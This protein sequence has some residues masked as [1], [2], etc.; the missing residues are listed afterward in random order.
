MFEWITQLFN[1]SPAALTVRAQML[2]PNDQ[3]R[4]LWDIFF[5]RVEV[6]SV[7]LADVLTLDDRAAADRREWNG[8][9]RLIPVSS[10]SLRQISMIPIEAYDKVDEKEMQ[11]LMERFIGNAQ[12]IAD[13]IG[14]SL[15]QRA[16]RLAMACWRRH[17]LDCFQAW[18]TGTVIQRN[19]QDA[20]KTYTASFGI[21]ASRILTAATAWNDAGVN[22]YDLLLAFI[23]AGI[24]AVGS[25]AGVMLRL[26]TL[27]VIQ[28]DAPNLGNSVKMTRADLESRIQ[29]DIGG[30]FSFY[31]NENSIDVFTDGGTAVVRTKVFPAQRVALIPAGN[32]VGYS[33]AAPVVRAMELSAQIPDAGIDIRGCTAFHNA[34]NAGKE[35]E[36]QCQLN[37]LGVPIEEK[38]FVTNCGV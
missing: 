17:E 31:V 12:L 8:P 26:A 10:P 25:C 36:L 22:A 9:G 1:L 19:P 14:V 21:D 34:H 29:D 38:I 27:K 20:T 6:N 32:A 2:S 4:L 3:G 13:T 18:T 35:L 24:D 7:D 33:G 30:P 11:H 23:E 28:A 37:I 16:D 5:P 15:P